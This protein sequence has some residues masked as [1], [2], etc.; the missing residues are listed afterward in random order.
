M[1]VGADCVSVVSA[2]S[3]TETQSAPT[4]IQLSAAAYL[5]VGDVVTVVASHDLSTAQFIAPASYISATLTDTSAPIPTTP[6]PT[7]STSPTQS[8]P[9]GSTIA[10]LTAVIVDSNGNVNP[11]D[12]T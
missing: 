2:Y 9:A 8:F 3:T 1:R 6:I 12:P 10:P 7:T 5:Q 11:V 4:L